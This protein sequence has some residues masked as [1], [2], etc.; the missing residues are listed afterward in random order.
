MSG[1]AAVAAAKR[2]LQAQGHVSVSLTLP[3]DGGK[4]VVTVT[5]YPPRGRYSDRREWVLW[6]DYTAGW[7]DL[8]GALIAAE[9]AVQQVARD[10]AAD[11]D[12]G[13]PHLFE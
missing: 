10:V 3:R 5:M 2:H 6:R 9:W 13:I 1:R 8:E 7:D 11:P 4:G 12:A